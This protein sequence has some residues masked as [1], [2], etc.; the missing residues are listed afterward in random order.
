MS[1]LNYTKMK[2]AL[3]L[4]VA[5]VFVCGSVFASEIKSTE[6]ENIRTVSLSGQVFDGI[7]GE[8]LAGVKVVVEETREIAYTDFNGSFS[9]ENLIPGTY[10]LSTAFISYEKS[11]IKVELLDEEKIELSLEQVS[12]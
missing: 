4:I 3:L 10:K 12:K 7:T 9:F 2:K 1:N 8:T 6:S 5:S 11:D